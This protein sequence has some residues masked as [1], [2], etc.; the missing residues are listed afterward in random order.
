MVLTSNSFFPP[1][2]FI[3]YQ[4]ADCVTDFLADFDSNPSEVSTPALGWG[5][6]RFHFLPYALWKFFVVFHIW[7]STLAQSVIASHIAYSVKIKY[8][9]ISQ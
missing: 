7:Q 1:F 6:I 5:I 9:M 3:L 2:N 4:F 8:S